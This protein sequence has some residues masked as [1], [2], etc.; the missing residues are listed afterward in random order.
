MT[1]AVSIVIPTQRRP[2]GLATAI[3]SAVAQTGVDFASLE[4]VVADNDQVPSAQAAVE[5][6]ARTAPFPVIY[7]HEPLAGVANVRNTALATARGGLIA[8]LDDDQEAPDGWLAALLAVRK[9][10]EADVVFAPV[11][12]RAPEDVVEHRAYFERFFSRLDPS[13]EGPI[14]HF[15]G[16]G[17][18]LLRR[19]S[20]PGGDKPFAVERNQIGGED[21]L[22]F[23]NM[24]AAGARFAWAPAAWVWEDPIPSRLT[25]R[26][27]LARAFGYGQGPTE[28]SWSSTPRDLVGVAKWMLVG[29]A[30]TAVHG[31]VA[32]AKLALR[33]P[34]RAEALD[35]AARGLGKTF[36]WGPFRLNFYG[37][38]A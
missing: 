31:P 30:Q 33:R 19:A 5:A 28:H 10:Y 20:L 18:S 9:A 13:T 25:L 29:L 27:T 8:F 38:S 12:A 32:L 23:G 4:L 35:R 3:A 36:W 21:D 2:Q 24:Q 7:V 15:Y 17:N 11:H 14:A 37:R 16:C 6:A 22:L 34:D 26:Y 1:I